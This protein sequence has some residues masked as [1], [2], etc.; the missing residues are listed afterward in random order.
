MPVDEL[1]DL[2][3]SAN[4]KPVYTYLLMVYILYRYSYEG[5]VHNCYSSSWKLGNNLTIFSGKKNEREYTVR[6]HHIFA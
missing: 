3:A 4:H 2:A 5:M 6:R 1:L